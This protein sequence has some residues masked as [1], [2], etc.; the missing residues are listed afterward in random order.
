MKRI[1]ILFFTLIIGIFSLNAQSKQAADTLAFLKW[2]P[3][4]AMGWN[5]WDCYRP[6]I[7]E[8]EVKANYVM[9]GYERL[10]PGTLKFPS[11]ANGKGFKALMPLK[12]IVCMTYIQ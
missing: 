9:D 6:T 11:S 4:P 5:S 8:S 7:T 10:Q 1:C 12:E 2:A 3:T